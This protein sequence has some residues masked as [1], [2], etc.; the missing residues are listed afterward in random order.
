MT[1]EAELHAQACAFVVLAYEVMN[2]PSARSLADQSDLS[3][4]TVRRLLNLDFKRPQLL[5]FQKLSYAA[6]IPLN[7]E[8]TVT[9]IRSRSRRVSVA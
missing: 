2:Q 3:L 9:N 5:T 1:L 4:S 6:G 8:V 7:L